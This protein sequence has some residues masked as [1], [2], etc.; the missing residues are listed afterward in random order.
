MISPTQFAQGMALLGG[1]FGREVDGPVSK[2]YYE[3]ISPLLTDEQWQMAVRKVCASE[4]FWPPCAILIRAGLGDPKEQ[5]AAQLEMV[6]D[7][8]KNHGGFRYLSPQISA[9][10]STA[11][12]AGI[13]AAGGLMKISTATDQNWPIIQKRF[14]EAYENAIAPQPMLEDGEDEPQEETRRIV[15]QVTE[16]LPYRD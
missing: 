12:W 3:A 10:F 13:S 9:G 11:T 6:V 7:T 8:L 1:T 16:R 14:R 15:A 5:S 2:L 4:T